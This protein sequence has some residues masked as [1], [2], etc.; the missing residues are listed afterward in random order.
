MK[1]DI[2]NKIRDTL[3]SIG[4]NPRTSSILSLWDRV[5]IDFWR[6]KENIIKEYSIKYIK[7]KSI[8][9]LWKSFICDYSKIKYFKLTKK[10]KWELKKQSW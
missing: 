4:V 2:L 10:I 3:K 5:R 9:T 6:N 8:E 1:I 7:E